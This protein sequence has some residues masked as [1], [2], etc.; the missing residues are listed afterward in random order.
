MIL[1]ISQR[2]RHHGRKADQARAGNRRQKQKCRTV[3]G[4]DDDE[5]GDRGAECAAEA[6]G[7]RNRALADIE[8]PCAAREIGDDERKQ[9]AENAGADAVEQLH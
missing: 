1:R 5:A 7:G 3:A 6:R 9:C 2:L 8:M 4:L